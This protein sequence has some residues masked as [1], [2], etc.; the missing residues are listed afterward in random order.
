MDGLPT[1]QDEHQ[2]KTKQCTFV[3]MISFLESPVTVK[4]AYCSLASVIMR[5]SI[6]GCHAK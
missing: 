4:Q 3:Q 5:V 6:V 1:T 2:T